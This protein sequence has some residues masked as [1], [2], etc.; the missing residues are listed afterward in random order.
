MIALHRSAALLVSAVLALPAAPPADA[1]ELTFVESSLQ[2]PGAPAA[3]VPGDLDGDGLGD[4]AVVVVYTEW[5][6]VGVTEQTEMDDIEGLVEV[7]TIVPVLFDRREIRV[8]RGLAE[9]GFAPVGLVAELP[10]SVLSLEPGPPGI[11]VVALTDAGLAELVLDG[12]V[13]TFRPLVDD[14]PATAGT[15]AFLAGLGLVQDLTGDGV[16]D[17]ALPALDGLALYPGNGSGV[18]SRPVSR[19]PPPEAEKAPIG[20]RID[21]P[22]PRV[23]DLDGDGLPDLH[24]RLARPGG[25][26]SRRYVRRNLGGGRFGEAVRIGDGGDEEADDGPGFAHLGRLAA[27]GPAAAIY[28]EELGPGEDAGLREEMEHAR[29]PHSLLHARALGGDLQVRAAAGPESEI[30]GYLMSDEDADLPLPGGVQDLNGDGLADLVTVTNDISLMKAMAVL[31]TRRL[32][33]DLG[34]HTWCQQPDGRFVLAPGEPLE[35]R[36]TIN[37]NDLEIR[38]RSL[39]AGD[40]DGDGRADF[41]QLGRKKLVGIHRG[42]ADCSYGERP[43]VE[44]RL[45][46][47]L[48]SLALAEARDLDGDGLTDLAVT[49]PRPVGEAG[50][51]APVRLDVYLS[52]T[53]GG[54]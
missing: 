4:L 28:L 52:R 21:V 36:L 15:G 31:A 27:T 43:D 46:G 54:R 47:E 8:F 25:G 7:L 37:L 50:V 2:L 44:I 9:G 51:S 6:Q 20:T 53:G 45:S 40:F 16:A 5:D 30:K 14:P 26:D 49:H 42:R 12:S 11:P 32:T 48:R 24:Y 1:T 35:S 18:A 19:T 41:V 29:E 17:V 33:L 39:F 3:L 34:F 10:L 22:L 38:R 23:E 13:P